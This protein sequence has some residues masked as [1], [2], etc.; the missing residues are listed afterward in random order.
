MKIKLTES[1]IAKIL[2]ESSEDYIVRA[3][4]L[5]GGIHAD[6]VA[7][8]D[9]IKNI[10]STDSGAKTRLRLGQSYDFNKSTNLKDKIRFHEYWNRFSQTT[11]GRGFSFEGLFAG[12]FGGETTAKLNYEDPTNNVKNPKQDVIIKGNHYSLKI[13][14]DD[15][16]RYS[17]GSYKSKFNHFRDIIDNFEHK[18]VMSFLRSDNY[19]NEL[20]EDFLNTCFDDNITFVFAFL[21]T[22]ERTIEY[23]LCPVYGENGVIDRILN[24]DELTSGKSVGFSI[25]IKPNKMERYKIKFPE[26][27]REEV[28]SYLPNENLDRPMD[29]VYSLFSD[30]MKRYLRP[31]VLNYLY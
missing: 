4:K 13:V 15:K 29:K 2:N 31:E 19:D 5:L 30:D 25:G 27:S 26:V 23:S 20:K 9:I 17:L 8:V 12:L 7:S 22:K 16:E 10:I 3:I 21:N 11:D 18:D 14:K 24:K 6:N 1:Q 28:E